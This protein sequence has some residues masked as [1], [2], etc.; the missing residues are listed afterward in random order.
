MYRTIAKSLFLTLALA[1]GVQVSA[2]FKRGFAI[3]IDPKS[4]REAK[5]EV[6]DYAKAIEQIDGLKVYILEDRWGVPDSIRAALISLHSQKNAPIEG[7][8]FVGD[9]PVAMVRD[10]Q[11][12]TSAFKMNQTTDRRQSS[13]PSDRY[14]DD[15]ELKFRHIDK[16]T[17]HNYHY[18]SLQADSRQYLEPTIYT[19]RIRPVEANGV[20]SVSKLKAFL[21]KAVAAKRNRTPLD[22]MLFFNGHGYVSDSYLVRIDEKAGLYEHFPW[23]QK[24]QNGISYITHEQQPVIKYTLMNELQRPDLDYAILHHHGADDTQYLDGIPPI[25][26]PRAAKEMIKAYLRANLH[27]GVDDKKQDKDS[28]IA[29]LTKFMD[30]PESWISDA[31]DPEIMKADSISDADDNLTISDFKVHG[32]KPNCRVVMIDACFTG[33]FHLDDCIADEYIFNPGQTVAVIANSV[34]SLQDK[35]SD[36]FM[37]LLGL[38]A[39]V[40]FMSQYCGYLENHLIGDPT[41][42]YAPVDNATDVNALLADNS[43]K[44]WTKYLKSNYADLQC[45]AIEKLHRA[46]KISSSELLSIFKTTKF[47][48]VRVQALVTLAKINDDNFIEALNL[49]VNDSYELVQRFTLNYI[50]K[51]G[52]FRL[53]PALISIA[54]SNN[55]SE[56]VNFSAQNALSMFP[57]D[58]L[59][60][61]FERQFSSDKVC[62]IEKDTVR[63]KIRR[64]LISSAARYPEDFDIVCATNDSLSRKRMFAIRSTR[65]FTPPYLIPRLIETVR[66]NGNPEIQLMILES[67]GW[68]NQSCKTKVIADFAKQVSEDTKY[69]PEVRNEALKTYNRVR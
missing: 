33:S 7:A 52:D 9:I 31:Y 53:V 22:Q 69:T 13:V 40:G 2:A 54:I 3:V 11:H 62:Y 17:L 20:I 19:G 67:L 29:K 1:L 61:E 41:F 56:R 36:Q 39:H 59:L 44:I 60:E 28:V 57:E 65:N 45:M 15:F 30:V 16:D 25:N 18:Y 27:H 63:Q 46:G 47:A 32:Y 55:T 64:A 34:N 10:A 38:G 23:L 49:G 43:A 50:A 5:A 48:L 51:S 21:K 37:G 58:K 35:W 68:R 12:L 6:S 24:Q 8:V 14:Y 4:Y 42:S 66:T 26:T